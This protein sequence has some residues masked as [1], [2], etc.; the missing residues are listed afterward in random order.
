MYFH[1]VLAYS[2][3]YLLWGAAYLVMKTL[4][5]NLPP[6]WVA[7]VRYSLAAICLTIL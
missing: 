1:K 3:V 4:V 6:F 7:R 5:R 2:A